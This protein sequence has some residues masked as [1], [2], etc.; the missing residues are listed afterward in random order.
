VSLFGESGSRCRS[1]G[2]HKDDRGFTRSTKVAP[3]A[4]GD[5]ESNVESPPEFEGSCVSAFAYDNNG[6]ETLRTFP[7]NAKLITVNDASGRPTRITGKD[8]TGAAKVDIGYSYAAPGGTGTSADRATV[9]TRTSHLE[10][11]ITAGAVTTY[12]Y[13]SLSRLKT[14][15]E[16]TG[17]TTR[18]SWTYAY[19]SAGNRTSQIRAGSTGAAA[20]TTGYGYDNANRLISTTGA[21][22]AWTYD[23]AGNQTKN[24]ATGQTASFNSR[25]AVTGIGATTYSAFGQ[26]NTEQLTR[27]ASSTRYLTSPIGLMTEDLGGAA[28]TFDRTPSGDAVGNRLNNGTRYYYATD[29]LG[30]VVGMFDKTGAYLGGYSYSPYGEQRAISAGTAMTDNSLRYIGG[31][32]DSASGLYKLGARYYDPSIGRFTQFDP[33]GQESHPYGY[34][35]CNPINASDPSGTASV[36]VI[37]AFAFTAIGAIAAVAAGV[38]GVLATPVTGGI[39]LA[40]AVQGIAVVVGIVTAGTGVIFGIGSLLGTC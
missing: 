34:A 8:G 25:G 15:T 38:A 24:G 2:R 1:A 26:G 6:A 20:G 21:P 12:A 17:T 31:Y 35:N 29:H 7:G 30:S 37:T 39:S 33:S 22:S 16:K 18:A 13:D 36:C 9:Q 11:G 40:G 10:T 3:S 27:N 19:D 32:L 28:R 4:K 23:S 5:H 14:A